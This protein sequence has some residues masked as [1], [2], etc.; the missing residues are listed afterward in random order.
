M[1]LTLTANIFGTI[2]TNPENAWG[3]RYNEHSA[4]TTN[5][6]VPPMFNVEHRRQWEPL[7]F[8]PMPAPKGPWST[9][10]ATLFYG[11]GAV[12]WPNEDRHSFTGRKHNKACTFSWSTCSSKNIGV[13]DKTAEASQQ[14][15]L[16]RHAVFRKAW[17]RPL[18]CT[19]NSISAAERHFTKI[20]GG[21]SYLY[22]S[23]VRPAG[24]LDSRLV[25]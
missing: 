23:I 21:K 7:T 2:N 25:C 5:V 15:W 19:R 10:D 1:K 18:Y 9:S 6:R 20:S 13:Q 22:R 8:R 11:L 3:E 14:L 17:F 16:G 12:E 4:N 24:P